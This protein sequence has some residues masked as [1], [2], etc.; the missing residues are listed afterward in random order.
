MQ[1]LED[2]EERIYLIINKMERKIKCIGYII[3]HNDYLINTFE[4]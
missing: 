1:V 3:R 2:K 4:E